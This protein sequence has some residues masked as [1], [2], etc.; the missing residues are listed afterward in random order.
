MGTFSDTAKNQ[1]LNNVLRGTASSL[2]GVVYAKLHT[3]DPGSA[4][5]SNAATETTRQAVTVGAASA[6]VI[7]STADVEW[8]SVSADETYA[9]VSFWDAS[10]GGNFLGRDD[11]PVSKAVTTGDT[12]RIPSGDLTFSI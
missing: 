10:S 9:W 2:A 1:M 12:F 4:G 7:T 11:L 5:T 8:S 3:G 6:G